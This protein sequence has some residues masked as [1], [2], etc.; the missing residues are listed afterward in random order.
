MDQRTE[1]SSVRVAWEILHLTELSVRRIE[2]TATRVV[3]AQVAGLI[4]LWTQLGS[5]ENGPPEVLAWASW[6][7]LV[8]A[9]FGLGVVVT[10]RRVT[11]FWTRLSGSLPSAD[12]P[13]DKAAELGLIEDLSDA[14]RD[15]RE[16]IHRLLQV[17]IGLGLAALVL[18]GLAYVVE[19]GFYAP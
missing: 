6:A 17:S 16:T 18:A 2:D 5:F 7:V 10:P 3:A 12:L 11:R 15:Q 4:A 14:L 1:A 19:K 9:I 13:L 8:V